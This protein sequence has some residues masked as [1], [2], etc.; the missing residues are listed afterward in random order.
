MSILM[1]YLAPISKGP[2]KLISTLLSLALPPALAQVMKVWGGIGVSL[3]TVLL[4]KNSM[5]IFSSTLSS[6]LI[7]IYTKHNIFFFHLFI[8]LF[9][10]DLG[11]FSS[12]L[13]Y[14][15]YVIFRLCLVHEIV[16]SLEK[17]NSFY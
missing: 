8:Y 6:P 14:N 10:E 4:S 3:T 9:F 11:K 13:G 15:N 5:S 7:K 1:P 17:M 16:I 2:E 12:V